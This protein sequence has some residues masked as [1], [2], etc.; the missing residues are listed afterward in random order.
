MH[1]VAISPQELARLIEEAVAKVISRTEPE[2]PK[3]E[4][5]WL[6]TAG[7]AELLGCHPKSVATFRRR[8]LPHRA[9]GPK[10]YRYERAAVLA[11]M[12]AR[13]R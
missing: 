1:I 5:A 10:T 6:D 2:A 8:G 4:A 3:P 11:W 13:K 9:L 7:V 12:T